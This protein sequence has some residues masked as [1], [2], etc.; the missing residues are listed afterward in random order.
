MNDF[1]SRWFD[2]RSARCEL[3]EGSRT[4]HSHLENVLTP[5]LSKKIIRPGV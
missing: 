4:V 2:L 1:H 5:A 3:N